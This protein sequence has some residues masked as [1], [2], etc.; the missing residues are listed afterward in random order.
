MT[1]ERSEVVRV[2]FFQ[3]VACPENVELLACK[4]VV[5]D[6]ASRGVQRIH[7]ELDC[8]R[9]V[10]MI[11]DPGRNLSSVG[12]IVQ[13]IKKLLLPFELSKDCWVRRS[14]NVAAHSL[15]KFALSSRS[16]FGWY[17]MPS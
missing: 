6:A 17:D 5:Q 11:N 10:Q 7:I 9:A 2:R 13:E 8:Q 4:N 1:K 12:P 16:C 3:A 14:A 15:A